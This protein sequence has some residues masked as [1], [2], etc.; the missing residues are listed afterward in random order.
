VCV[1]LVLAG[2]TAAFAAEESPPEEPPA[3]KKGLFSRILPIPIFI[4]E[5]AVGYG[6]GAAIGYFHQRKG[7]SDEPSLTSPAFTA[8]TTPNDDS[9]GKKRPP[10]ITGVAGAKTENGTWGAGIGHSASWKDDRIRYVGALGYAH[11]ITDFYL[12][13][14]PLAF[15]LE[16]L[17]FL[18][19]IKFRVR[20]SDFFVGVKG[21]AL[22]ADLALELDLLEDPEQFATGKSRNLG[23]AVQAVYDSRDNTFT[24]NYGQNFTLELW[25]YDKGLGGNYDYWSTN[26]KLLSFH[27][28]HEKF[29]LGFRFDFKAVD[30]RPPI[31]GYPWITLR[32]IPALRY[33]NETAGVFE[34]EGRWTVLPKWGLIG[35][36]GKGE[37]D[38]DLPF[39]ETRD[40]ILAGGAGIRY[41]FMPDQSLWVGI[42]Y[43]VGP[44]K[45]TWYLQA[46]HAW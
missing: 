7:E 19:D 34:I 22:D 21:F 37:V 28:L 25:R 46:G 27:Q 31:Y 5:P 15:D 45:K 16:G 14:L 17:M 8:G 32:G 9:E 42:D 23:L 18:Q 38:G 1:G 29:V 24:P 4:T 35:F 26:L 33:Q 44:E 30:G 12:F 43:A 40:D 39:F 10:N 36:V 6:L 2:H 41:L 11:V 3:K 13:D 20:G